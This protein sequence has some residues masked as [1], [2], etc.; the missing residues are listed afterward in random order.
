MS[1]NIKLSVII[2]IYKVEQYLPR[3]LDSLVNQSL[4][5]IE[6]ICINDGSPDNSIDILKDYQKK[7]GDKIVIIDKKNEG[8]WRG[9]KDGIKAARGEYIGFIDSDDY[10]RPGYAEKLYNAAK[11]SDSDIVVCGFSRIDLE[12][13]KVYSNEMCQE[14]RDIIVGKNTDD[15]LAINGAPWNKI[16]K[17][18]VLKNM[19]DLKNPPRILDDMMFQL[20]AFLNVNRISFIKDNL[21]CYMVRGTSIIN[22]IKKEQLEST[23]AAMLEVKGIYEKDKRSDIFMP[24]LSAMAYLHFGI[25]LMFRMSYDKT[26]NFKKVL[27]ENTKYLDENFSDWRKNS[28]IKLTHI[29][30]EKTPNIKLGIIALI[31]KIHGFRAFLATYRFMIDK[32]KV[33]IKW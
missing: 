18:A 27:A 24:L 7:Y 20:L 6:L 22:T 10:V 16:F 28:Y 32:L 3:C 19:L 21:I 5:E 4:Q 9:R 26:C 12:T 1:S 29:I 33:D 2:P 14:K 25:S 23:Y 13:G 17:A 8:V 15:I 31:D 11:K 30:K